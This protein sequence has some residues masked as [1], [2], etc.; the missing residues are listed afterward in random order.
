MSGERLTPSEAWDEGF[1][2]GVVALGNALID[3]SCRVGKIN[4]N[5]IRDVMY[6]ILERN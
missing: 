3:C 6:T 2:D 4:I 5:D 1:N